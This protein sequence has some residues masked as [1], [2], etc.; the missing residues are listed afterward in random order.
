MD[1][2]NTHYS[3]LDKSSGSVTSPSVGH[4]CA[5]V[6]HDD[7]M[8]YRARIETLSNTDVTIRF[9]D[10]GNTQQS[11]ISDLKEINAQFLQLPVLAVECT[12]GGQNTSWTAEET[13]KF[14]MVTGEEKLTVEV[15][16]QENGKYVVRILQGGKCVTDSLLHQTG[17][18]DF[19]LLFYTSWCYF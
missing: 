6:F 11:K 13:E 8:W 19:G 14:K 17:K 4:P 2:I 9:I 12:L 16:G 15:T 1:N 5:A 3:G 7:N 18:K 10:Y